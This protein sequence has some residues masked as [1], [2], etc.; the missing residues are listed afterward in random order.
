[1]KKLLFVAVLLFSLSNLYALIIYRPYNNEYMNSVPCYLRILD[2]NDNDVTYEVSKA[3]YTYYDRPQHFFA[4]KNKLYLMGGM[5]MHLHLIPG[6]YKISFYTPA[7]KYKGF[8][9][10]NK[11]WESNTFIYNTENPLNVLFVTPTANDD[12][13][14]DG[15]WYLDYKA[16]KFFKYT[17]PKQIE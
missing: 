16:P 2:E 17:I 14:Y 6:R 5:A 8:F 3:T 13:F 11:T 1:M 9:T 12:Y 15:G 4:Y 10:G 7:D